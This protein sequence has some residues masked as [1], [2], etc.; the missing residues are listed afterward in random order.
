MVQHLWGEPGVDFVGISD[1]AH[2]I[3]D[4]LRKYGRVCVLDSKEKYGTVRVYC[5]FGWTG[6]HSITHPGYAYNRYPKWLWNVDTSQ[7]VYK[8]FSVLNKIVVPYQQW[9]Y[10]RA[11]KKAI[12]KWPHLV[13]EILDGADWSELLTGLSVKYDKYR[14]ENWTTTYVEEEKEAE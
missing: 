12:A 6:F 10:R 14:S 4:N 1:A 8:A 9:L 5:V 2:F 11:Y 7:P 3:G 13:L